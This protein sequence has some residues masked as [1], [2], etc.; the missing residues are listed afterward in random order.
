MLTRILSLVLFALMLVCNQ[1]AVIERRAVEAR[2]ADVDNSMAAGGWNDGVVGTIAT[3]LP[4]EVFVQARDFLSE[5]DDET[6]DLLSHIVSRAGKKGGGAKTEA[7]DKR[8]IK[9]RL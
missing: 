3:N 9:A 1:A 6:V 2:E 4:F 8:R 7:I 5:L